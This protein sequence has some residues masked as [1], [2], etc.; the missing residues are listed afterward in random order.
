MSGV[1]WSSPIPRR[2]IASKTWLIFNA[3]LSSWSSWAKGLLNPPGNIFCVLFKIAITEGIM[4]FWTHHPWYS[5]NYIHL[6]YIRFF[7]KF[8]KLGL[9]LNHH[10]CYFRMFHKPSSYWGS[11][12]TMEPPWS[13]GAKSEPPR[14]AMES[15]SHHQQHLP[16]PSM[17]PLEH[18]PGRN[19][20]EHMGKQ[21]NHINLQEN[22]INMIWNL[23]I[24]IYS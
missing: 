13:Q 8:P 9:P 10:P 6:I 19:S 15:H 4:K 16:G 11:P 3:Q 1:I 20:W 5:G 17:A 22:K 14:P 7:W 21:K 23:Y 12:M 2:G 18:L 24:Y